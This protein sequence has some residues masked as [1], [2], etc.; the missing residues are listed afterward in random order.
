MKVLTSRSL[1]LLCVSLP[2]IFLACAWVYFANGE[3]FGLF[4]ASIT[5]IPTNFLTPLIFCYCFTRAGTVSD[6]KQPKI[7]KFHLTTAV[8]IILLYLYDQIVVLSDPGGS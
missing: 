1:I 2:G 7:S 6:I 8:T 4:I 5:F 3:L